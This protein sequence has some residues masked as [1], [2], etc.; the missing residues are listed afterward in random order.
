[1]LAVTEGHVW[2]TLHLPTWTK[3]DPEA[4]THPAKPASPPVWGANPLLLFVQTPKKEAETAAAILS[5]SLS[6]VC[7]LPVVISVSGNKNWAP[8]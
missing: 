1:M 5:F 8:R 3:L 2:D 7:V 6:A 4:E